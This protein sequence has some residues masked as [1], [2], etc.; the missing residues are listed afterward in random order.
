MIIRRILKWLGIAIVVVLLFAVAAVFIAY[1][2]SS[3]DCAR[4]SALTGPSMKAVVY[5]DFGAPDVLSLRDVDK[6]VPNDDQVLVKIHATSVNPLDWH[7]VRGTPLIAR[8]MGMG[9]RKPKSTR[10]GVDYSGVVEAVG[11]T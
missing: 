11:K 4:Q 6:P 8:A 2:R 7:F 3:N 9:L 1:W 5:C 10:L